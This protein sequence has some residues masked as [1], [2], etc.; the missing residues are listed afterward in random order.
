MT[1]FALLISALL[2]GAAA[3]ADSI[4]VGPRPLALVAQMA[5]SP[6]KEKLLSCAKDPVARTRF[7][8]GHRGAPLEYPEHTS[9]SYTAAAQ[10]GA[11]LVECDVTFTA[12][13]ALVCRH[14]QDDLHETTNILDTELASTC[15]DGE[16]ST[17]DITL[18]QFLTLEGTKKGAETGEVMTLADSIA[19][20]QKLGVKFAPELKSAAV[21]MPYQGMR[22]EDYAQSMIDA[23]KEA[24][25][26]PRDVWPQSFNLDDVLY[27]LKAEPEFGAQA[28]YLEG[29]YR[30]DG[31]SPEKPDTW[32]N[33][34]TELKEMGV[35]YVAPPLWVLLRLQD[36]EI[37]PSTYAEQAREAG[38][39]IIAWTVERSGPLNK[40]GGWYYQTV[41]D[42]ITGDGMM[43]EVIDVLA[44]DVGV[45]GIFSDWAGT[46]SY[47]ASCMGLD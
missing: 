44:Q 13:K 11:G 21:D 12:D 22:Q 39:K 43:Y 24:G 35:N 27:W 14:A 47:Y 28:V 15:T 10:M 45:V 32:R 33:S 30:D 41:T 2:C 3:H 5:D 46:T 18:A 1:R 34:M 23:F 25:V 7:S 26:P 37:V 17:A 40:G 20:M 19:L 8:L 36:G 9:E 42:A 6:L 4:D 16:C 31:W 29:S 38:L